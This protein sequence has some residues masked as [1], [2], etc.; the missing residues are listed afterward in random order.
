MAPE[1]LW[2][3]SNKMTWVLISIY[4]ILF[5]CPIYIAFIAYGRALI[6]VSTQHQVI[7]KIGAFIA[8]LI[9]SVFLVSPL[10]IGLGM[11]ESWREL[12]SNNLLFAGYFMILY[13]VSV[14]PGLLMFRRNYLKR[15]R[16]AGFFR[17]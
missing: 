12:F 17:S 8:Y 1:N 15:L 14:T 9:F 4:F 11:V 5:S 10:F 7:R 16:A 13:G 3:H 6:L 2:E